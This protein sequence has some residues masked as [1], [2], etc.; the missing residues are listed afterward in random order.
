MVAVSIGLVA[1]FSSK[2]LDIRII[3]KEI[4]G[5]R[6]TINFLEYL[7]TSSSILVKNSDGVPLKGMIDYSS[8]HTNLLNEMEKF[9][10]YE[11]YFSLIMANGEKKV[12]SDY[13]FNVFTTCYKKFDMNKEFIVDSVALL[14]TPEE[15]PKESRWECEPVTVRLKAIRTP[16][17][18]LA[19]WISKLCLLEGSYERNIPIDF[20][21]LTLIKVFTQE[22]KICFR[23]EDNSEICRPFSCE[24]KIKLSFSHELKNECFFITLKKLKDVIILET[25]EG[26]GYVE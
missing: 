24:K 3:K 6:D 7:L 23:F 25:P 1:L 12:L 2:F 14:C 9:P 26:Y 8:L 20:S 4:E 21:T 22:N 19:S 17:T 10:E 18:E 13:K 11:F 5:T 16:L 15:L